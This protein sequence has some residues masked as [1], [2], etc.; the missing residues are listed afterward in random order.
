MERQEYKY[1]LP[2]SDLDVLRR[3]ILP[4]VEQDSH[5]DVRP[6][7]EYTVRSLY[8]DTAALDFYHDKLEGVQERMKIRIRVYNEC[9]GR[10]SAF[11]EIKKKTG[12]VIDKHR[13]LL[14][15]RNVEPLLRDG[16]VARH[17]PG[18]NGG[19]PCHEN[20]SRFLFHVHT[21]SLRPCVTTIYEREAYFSR[22]DRAVRLTIDKNLRF[23]PYGTISRLFETNGVAYA[24]PNQ[25]VFELKT[26]SGIPRW[27]RQILGR[28][29]VVQEAV[30]KY[31]ICVYLRQERGN[32][33]SRTIPTLWS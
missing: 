32:R 10:D 4:Y 26:N 7:G 1:L 15:Y 13:A 6:F 20:A 24:L 30:S 23:Q 2:L 33:Y 8:L 3:M 19:G 25:F 5:A 14:P 21:R 12:R 28:F 31:V 18:D 29:D 16:D 27:F 22:W 11:L 17:I 9:T